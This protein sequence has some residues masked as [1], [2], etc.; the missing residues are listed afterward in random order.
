MTLTEIAPGGFGRNL[1]LKENYT[2]LV[3]NEAAAVLGGEHGLYSRDTRYL[4]RYAWSVGWPEAGD[5]R[6]A[7]LLLEHSPRPDRCVQH[8]A[9]MAG[10]TQVVAIAR[11][12]DIATAAMRDA[13]TVTN[14]SL[15]RQTVTLTLAFETDFAD[16]FQAR[17]WHEQPVR[18][19]GGTVARAPGGASVRFD[20]VA[21]DGLEQGLTLTFTP[22]PSEVSA[23][24]ATYTLELRPGESVSLTVDALLR[25]PLETAALA[26]RPATGRHDPSPPATSSHVV[27]YEGWLESFRPLLEGGP[28]AAVLRR[29][30]LDLRALL[31][32][33]E[34]GPIFAAGIPWFVT[35]FGRD[36]ILTALMLLDRR[37][38]VARGTLRY[39]ASLQGREYDAARSE[40]PGKILHEVRQGELARTGKVPFGRY[41]GSIDATLLFMVL[42]HETYRRDGDLGLLRELRPNLEAALGWLATDADPDGD[43]FVEFAGAQGGNGLS[44]QSWKDSHD[45]LSHAD[46]TLAK[47]AVAVAEVQGY[48]YAALLAAAGCLGDLGETAEA[49]RLA[50]RADELKARFHDAFWLPDLGTYALALDFDKR[51]LEVLSSDA[52]QLLWTGIVPEAFAPTL[53]ATLMSDR[54]FSGWGIRTLG[55]RE[56]RYNPLSYHNGSVWP[57][58]TALIAAGLRRYGFTEQASTLRDALFDLAASQPDLRP[59]ELVAGYERTD[60][61]PVPYPV[62]CRPQAWSSAALAYLGDWA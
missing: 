58:D 43:G 10:P 6:E 24:A 17:G 27:S 5:D 61:P 9:V 31:L 60:S 51:P 42:L 25:D 14:T 59:P 57:H 52:G 11:R 15:A 3:A 2:F 39:L 46:G 26:P 29:A 45:A 16:L 20:H 34:H 19:E 33:S 18:F 53:A 49:G 56:A 4:S 54:L 12:L 28:H 50:R 21:S 22:A 35:A 48:A 8:V 55:T 62:A 30:A 47:G 7:Q 41:Y 40:A 23:G 36:S 32:F 44:V 13:V 37:P 1:V 38:D